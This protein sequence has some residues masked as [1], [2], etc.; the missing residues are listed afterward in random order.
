MFLCVFLQ[1]GFEYRVNLLRK[2]KEE[3]QK[4]GQ[5]GK[6]VT[7][8][9]IQTTICWLLLPLASKHLLLVHQCL[10]TNLIRLVVFILMERP[11][12]KCLP[13][14]DQEGGDILAIK[15]LYLEPGLPILVTITGRGKDCTPNGLED[16]FEDLW[17][18]DPAHTQA[19]RTLFLL[20]SNTRFD[21]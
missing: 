13:L 18:K 21:L 17:F 16:S 10:S 14:V 7:V 2:G 9:P 11:F 5:K 6:V 20:E 19:I 4:H 15:D 12:D 3:G 8:P 1:C